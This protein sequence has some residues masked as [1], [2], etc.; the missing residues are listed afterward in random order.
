MCKTR[1]GSEPQLL[2][3]FGRHRHY[4]VLHSISLQSCLQ[5]NLVVK[6]FSK[7]LQENESLGQL[8]CHPHVQDKASNF[9]S[10]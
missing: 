6:C 7:Q 10:K 4:A 2:G 1:R 5:L 3:P 8:Q 9:S